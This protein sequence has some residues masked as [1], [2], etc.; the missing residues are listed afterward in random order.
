MIELHRLTKRFGPLAAVD[1]LRF[2]V[3]TGGT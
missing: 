3:P 1:D 2:T